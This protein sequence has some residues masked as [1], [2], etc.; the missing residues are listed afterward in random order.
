M[1]DILRIKRRPVGGAAGA[2]A[3][4]TIASA[5]IAFNEQ[6]NVLYYGKGDTGAGIATSIIPIGGPGGFLPLPGGTLTG[7]LSFGAQVGAT[8]SDL[9]KHLTLHTA[10]YGVSITANRIN[11]VSPAGATISHVQGG[12]DRLAVNATATARSRRP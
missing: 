4:G 10:G 5:E 7:G 6:D 9:S 3:A 2:P 12:I 8:N 1:A 11:I